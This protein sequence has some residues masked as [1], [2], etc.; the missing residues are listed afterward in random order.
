MDQELIP[1]IQTTKGRFFRP[2][3]IK[4]DYPNT[5][6]TKQAVPNDTWFL[7]GTFWCK[8]CRIIFNLDTLGFISIPDYQ[9]EKIPKREFFGKKI[10]CVGCSYESRPVKL[11][12][13]E[14]KYFKNTR[15]CPKCRKIFNTDNGQS[16]QLPPYTARI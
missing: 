10:N 8:N 15:F 9:I 14:K 16:L 5:I 2:K 3:C 4:C 12:N 11:N 6:P 1:A 13:I 7:Q